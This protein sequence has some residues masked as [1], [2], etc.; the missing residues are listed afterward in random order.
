M[1]T[2]GIAA[3]GHASPQQARRLA[4][5]EAQ[6]LWSPAAPYLNTASFGLPPRPAWDALQEAL[7]D[8][9]HG[10]TSWE[11]WC[12][13]ID[14]ARTSFARLVGVPTDDVAV[15]GSV[16]ELLGLVA[17][18]LPTGAR[19]VAPEIDFTSLLYPFLAHADRGVETRT[20]PL[21]RL[22]ESIDS[23][24]TVVAASVVQSATGEIVDLEAVGAAAREHDAVVVLDATHACGWL[25][26]DAAGADFVA[27]AAYKW[28][29]APR[30]TAFLTV[31][32][33]RREHL[34]PLAANWW[35]GEDPY[36]T[37][38][39]PP[40]LLAREARRF[41]FSPAWFSWV[42]T[43]PALELVERIGVEAIHAHDLA[44]AN[45]F[46][47]GLG[48][49]PGDSA[50]VQVAVPDAEER[51]RR[52]G[53]RAAVRAGTLRASFHVYNTEGDVDAALDALA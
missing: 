28:L 46:R 40:L 4:I 34:R 7:A 3:T 31:R 38:Y 53:I 24:T 19:V 45:R 10:R 48:L 9:R 18:S 42:G 2:S 41:D 52:A 50:I 16:S 36:G 20:V 32:P 22:A 25:P 37:Y 33:D 39:G 51:L 14:Q 44:L 1:P 30:G 47:A 23:R 13:T 17:A 12:A 49:P 11:G 21:A 6:A 26:I 27:A 8:W 43:A 15:G 5:A 29:M 35:A